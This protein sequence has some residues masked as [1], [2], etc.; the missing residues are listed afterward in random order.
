MYINKIDKLIDSVIDKFY[1]TGINNNLFKKIITDPNFVKYQKQINE[2]LIDFFNLFDDYEIRQIVSNEEN[3]QMVINIVYRYVAYYEFLMIGYFYQGKIETYINNIVEF[4]NNQSNYKLKI[5]NFFNSENNAILIKLVELIRNINYITTLD[6]TKLD[7]L[8]KKTTLKP[9]IEFV[10]NLIEDIGKELF[11][12]NFKLEN[13]KGDKNKQAHNIVKTVIF[14]ELYVKQEKQEVFKILQEVEIETGIYTYIDIVIPTSSYIDYSSIENI[15]NEK[16]LKMGVGEQFYE[17][18]EN[19]DNINKTQTLEDKIL[20]LLKNKQIVPV[21]DDFLLYNKETEKYDKNSTEQS[22]KRKENTKIKYIINKIYTA[23]ELYSDI[24]KNKIKQKNIE[25]IFFPP[26]VNRKAIIV[27]SL[28]DTRLINKFFNIGIHTFENT[29][30]YNDLIGYRLYPFINFKDLPRDG[31]GIKLN[32]NYDLVRYVSVDPDP[33]YDPYKHEFIQMRVGGNN[34][35]VNIVGLM[36]KPKSMIAQCIAS[37]K[38][39]SILNLKDKKNNKTFNNGYKG[40]SKYLNTLIFNNNNNDQQPVLWLFDLEKDQVK[41]DNYVQTDKLN[42]Q[43]NMKLVLGKLYDD[44]VNYTYDFL[45]SEFQK[46]KSIP[47][48]DSYRYFLNSQHKLFKLTNNSIIAQL[49][50]ILFYDKA[51]VTT[52]EYDKKDD[53]FSG[54]QG[55]VIKLPTYTTKKSNEIPIFKI[56]TYTEPVTELISKPDDDDIGTAICQHNITWDMISA[57]RKRNPNKFSDLLY[58]FVQQYVI[59]DQEGLYLCKSCGTQLDIKN[60]VSDGLYD[61]EKG[62]FVLL[63]SPMEI[64]LEDLREYEKIKTALKSIEKILERIAI[65][66]NIPML[67]GMSANVKLKRRTVVKD[68]I[69]LILHHNKYLK[70]KYRKRSDTT[71]QLYGI[72]KNLTTMFVFDLDNTIFVYSSKE[73]DYYKPIKYNNVISYILIILLLEISEDQLLFLKSD[74]R[75]NYLLFKKIGLTMFDGIKILKNNKGDTVF[76]KNYPVLC[77]I[78]Y[79]FSCLVSHYKIWKYE[80]TE[81]NKKTIAYSI[82][83]VIINSIIDILNSILEVNNNNNNLYEKIKLKFYLR[84]NSIYNDTKKLDI[85]EAAINNKIKIVG[86]KK[87]FVN[88]S[89]KAIILSGSY[90]P[91]KYDK[92]RTYPS[93][94]NSKMYL[95]QKTTHMGKYE[96]MNCVTNCKSGDFHQWKATKGVF[97]CQLCNETMLQIKNTQDCVKAVQD[98]YYYK[99]LEQLAI[100]YCSSGALHYYSLDE[101]QNCSVCQKCNYKLFDKLSKQEL[102][103]LENN[104][105]NLKNMKQKKFKEIKNKVDNYY[106]NLDEKYHSV[107]HKLKEKYGSTKEHKNDYLKFVDN[108][109]DLLQTIIGKN[110]NINN[111]HIYI[112]ENAYIFDHD[113]EGN[114]LKIPI[115][116]TEDQNKIH[117]KY[118]HH[119]FKRDVIYYT[120]KEKGHIDVF[121]DMNSLKLLGYKDYNRDYILINDTN[122]YMIINYSVKNMIKILGYSSVYIPFEQEI[123]ERKLDNIYINDSTLIKQIFSDINRNR[124]SILKKSMASLQRN[125]NKI[126]YKF[127]IEQKDKQELQPEEELVSNYQKKLPEF[128]VMKNKDPKTKIFKSW[129]AIDNSLTFK[130]LNGKTINI[131]KNDKYIN[132][133]VFTD[134]DYHGNLILFYIITE[135]TKLLEYNQNKFIKSNLAFFCIDN[136]KYL[137]ELH[138]NDKIKNTFDIKRFNYLIN[139]GPYIIDTTKKG[140]GLTDDI[141]NFKTNDYGEYIDDN[142]ET[143]E[144]INENIDAQEEMDGIEDLLVNSEINDGFDENIVGASD[145]LD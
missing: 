92:Q 18:I 69:D 129:K 85:F 86:D 103:V 115:I 72:R 79:I 3:V 130:N 35:M 114:L 7:T 104:L 109:I 136:I 80:I 132:Y 121:Y 25:N 27:N 4:S 45:V 21:V 52:G 77:Y 140:H 36:Y 81:E 16:L 113:H 56:K 122:Q 23:S 66:S 123:N 62:T 94:V 138:N 59:E 47:Y 117:Y 26:L 88:N 116:I 73:R 131:N 120:N 119:Y 142:L 125:I 1:T 105:I 5:V 139:C 44:M 98:N 70:D 71:E 74:K 90:S 34:M 124:I 13:L 145:R 53:V 101:K 68:A 133:S 31:F 40:S 64:P 89:I 91:I 96:Y 82:Q 111:Q 112:K 76:I 17:L 108:F 43:E 6:I 29:E 110:T 20:M 102:I 65:I 24:G 97:V 95:T 107:I 46:H 58:E 100:K 67:I 83:K 55:K 143:D 128:D 41:L 141:E 60:Y 75:C 137:F 15:L 32:G 48:F 57:F 144:T 54:L 42:V 12:E 22:Y 78:I 61:S 118:N 33:K 38:I 127:H 28:E 51:D 87:L 135:L 126:K 39:K 84:L 49:K 63:S 14:R 134:Y 8:D 2:I 11:E 50:K 93:C 106:N 99:K 19:A 9:A 30:Y 37:N 10:N